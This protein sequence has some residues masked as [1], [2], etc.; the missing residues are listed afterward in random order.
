MTC[1][2]LPR[3]WGRVRMPFNEFLPNPSSLS[4]WWAE[5]QVAPTWA[6]SPSWANPRPPTARVEFTAVVAGWVMACTGIPG[7]LTRDAISVSP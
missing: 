2:T 5:T 6:K 3:F 4:A 1:S 7:E